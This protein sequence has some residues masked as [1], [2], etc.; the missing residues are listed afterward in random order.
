MFIWSDVGGYSEK[1][2]P[3]AGCFKLAML[4]VAG[5]DC[6]A[7]VPGGFFQPRRELG[8]CS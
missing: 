3:G 7:W 6:L 1:S 5:T 4:R 8:K 2:S